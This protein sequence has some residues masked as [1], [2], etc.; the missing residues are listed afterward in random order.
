MIKSVSDF[1]SRLVDHERSALDTYDLKHGPTIGKM[2]EGLSSN[3]LERAISPS[4]CLDVVEGFICDDT[5][6]MSGQID[7]MLVKGEG[8]LIPFTSSYK[9]NVD[10]VIAVIEVKKTLYKKDIQESFDLLRSVLDRRSKNVQA[11][12]GAKGVVDISPALRVFAEITGKIAPTYGELNQ[13]EFHEQMIYHTLVNELLSPIRISWGHHGYSTEI[14]LRNG[15]LEFLK[16]NI[17]KHGYGPGSFPQLI[18]SGEYSL[19]AATGFPFRIPMSTDIWDFYLSSSHNPINLLLE[20]VWTRLQREFKLTGLWG[21]DLDLQLLNPLLGTK[22]IIRDQKMGWEFTKRKMIPT[23]FSQF[24]VQGE[25]EPVPLDIEQF[26]AINLLCGGGSISK[27]DPELIKFV[28]E[29]GIDVE[30]FL[31]R[32]VETR[33]VATKGDEIRLITEACLCVA[34]PDGKFYAGENNSGRMERWVAKHSGAEPR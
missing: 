24:P 16:D 12:A 27:T 20:Y 6:E 4:L 14:G 33:L 34:M 15:F 5:E 23:D 26:T 17:G 25:W 11:K 3:I 10:N 18:I 13:F 31:A 21:E 28:A 7:C 32:L 19:M 8:E 29:K 1:L 2:Y 9:W 30:E 22:A